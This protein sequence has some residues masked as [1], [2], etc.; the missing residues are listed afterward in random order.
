MVAKIPFPEYDSLQVISRLAD[1]RV[2]YRGFYE[3]IRTTWITSA[4]A[5]VAGGGCP[6]T[7]APINLR[8]YTDSEEEAAARKDSLINLYSPTEVQFQYEILSSLRRDHQLIFCPS[9]GGHTV[10]GTLDHYLPKTVFP[11]FAVLIANLTPM[12]NA[13]QEAKGA[14]Y[15]T[16]GNQK[17]FIHGYYDEINFPIYKVKIEGDYKKPQFEFEFEDG[18]PPEFE[19][20][21]KEHVLGVNVRSRFLSYCET[22]HVHLLKTARTLRVGGKEDQLEFT[23]S[24]FLVAAECNSLNC[25]EAIFYRAVLRS[26][27]LLAYLRY[28]ELPS[29]F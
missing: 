11:E 5:Y 27:D 22:K 25:W 1:E 29:S 7:I 4:Q 28:G 19:G 6:T 14:E 13:C 12:C 9:C 16:E 15:L 17:K 26:T 21:V 24:M 20:L 3:R 23:I 8:D 18:I 10:P 2:R